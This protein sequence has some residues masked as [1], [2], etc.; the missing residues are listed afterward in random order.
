MRTTLRNAVISV[1]AIYICANK[2]YFL[3]SRTV[4]CFSAHDGK[5]LWQRYFDGG[6]FEHFLGSAN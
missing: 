4:Y 3:G 2:V 1:W 5:L 6:S